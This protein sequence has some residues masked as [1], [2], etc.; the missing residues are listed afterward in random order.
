GGS[1]IV[2]PDRSY[3]LHGFARRPIVGEFVECGVFAGGTAHLLAATLA[4]EGSV[5]PLHLFDTFAGMPDTA[6]PERDFHGPGDFGDTSLGL[7]QRRLAAYTNVRYH[8]GFVPDTFAE[9]DADVRL[10][11][12]HVDLDIY[13]S[14]LAACD[15]WPRV[16]SGGVMIFDDYGFW[17]LRHAARRAVDEYFAGQADKP[18]VLATGQAIVIR[19]SWPVS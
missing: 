5:A 15:L 17:H 7:V 6:Q 18:I 12:V 3:V 4:A 14:V 13:P 8:P 16:V 9:L 10:A 11:F 19:S 2:A 1:M